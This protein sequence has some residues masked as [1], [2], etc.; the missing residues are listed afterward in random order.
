MPRLPTTFAW[1]T[2][3]LSVRERRNETQA[4]LAQAMGCSV[5][6]VSK[7]ECGA[8]VPTAKH[9]RLLERLATD[10]GYPPG[11]WPKVSAAVN[12]TARGAS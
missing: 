6:A 4:E 10:A 12:A 3:V 8:A 1:S 2:V 11:D 5:F 7:W 9:R